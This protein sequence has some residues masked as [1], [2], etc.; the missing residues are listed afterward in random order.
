MWPGTPDL[1]VQWMPPSIERVYTRRAVARRNQRA[2]LC[3]VLDLEEVEITGAKLRLHRDG[4]QRKD[5]YSHHMVLWN[6]L[7]LHAHFL[8]MDAGWKILGRERGDKSKVDKVYEAPDKAMRLFSLSRAWKCFGQWLLMNSS[9]FGGNDYG[10]V[11]FNIHDFL[12]DLKNTML[13]LEHEV[14]LPKQSLS[15]LN[16]WQLLDPFMAVVCID[17]KVAALR[18]GVAL[19]AVNSTVTF[20]SHTES[21]LLSI[22]NAGNP[23]WLDHANNYNSP[24]PR[25]RKNLL[26][27]LQSDDHDGN[28]S[29]SKQPCTF[30]TSKSSQ[31]KMDQGLLS[32]EAIKERSIRGTSHRIVMGLRDSTALSSSGTTCLNEKNKLPHTNSNLAHDIQDKSDPLYFPPSYSSDYLVENV[33]I[34]D[35]TCHAYAMMETA[36]LD[37]PADSPNELV[38]S[39]ELLFSHEMDEMLLGTLDGISNAQHFTA[40]VSESQEENTNAGDRPSG[41][42]SRLSE[43]DRYSKANQK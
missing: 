2:K 34:K 4:G 35:P 3:S 7:R 41:P 30:G 17:K 39:A 9:G 36:N 18:N 24:H 28:S 21:K 8:M 42:S 26:P 38:L 16:Q 12:S 37:N 32:M 29:H 25:S 22:R 1:M 11:W 43:K 20:V 15:F 19:K 14:R 6:H 10:R 40:A 27:L 13:C 5:G 33:Q 23:L 31:Y